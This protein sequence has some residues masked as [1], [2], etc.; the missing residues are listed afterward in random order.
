MGQVSGSAD[1]VE[2]VNKSGA[3]STKGKLNRP[4]CSLTPFKASMRC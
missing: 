1:V 2:E 3:L 4:R